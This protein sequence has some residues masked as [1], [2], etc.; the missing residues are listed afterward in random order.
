MSAIPGMG[1]QDPYVFAAGNPTPLDVAVALLQQC[2]LW[3]SWD[4][5]Q[6]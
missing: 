2:P 1:W 5:P 6:G 4:P 3:T